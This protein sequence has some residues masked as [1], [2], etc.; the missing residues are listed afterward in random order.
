MSTYVQVVLPLVLA[1]LLQDGEVLLLDA[2]VFRLLAV[3]RLLLFHVVV[4]EVF[5]VL[6]G[7]RSNTCHQAHHIPGPITSPQ[8]DVYI[9]YY[10][11]YLNY[12][13][14]SNI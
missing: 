4:V 13:I 6:L 5:D 7:F 10:A 3:H 8:I 14:F 12:V 11:Q 9:H 1:D 2:V